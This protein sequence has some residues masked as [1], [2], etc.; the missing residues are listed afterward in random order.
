VKDQVAESPYDIYRYVYEKAC[1]S[2][3]KEEVIDPRPPV[4]PTNPD[5]DS[6]ETEGETGFEVD[7]E[8]SWLESLSMQTWIIFGI[9]LVSVSLGSYIIYKCCTICRSKIKVSKQ[10]TV[11]E[12]DKDDDDPFASP[13]KIIS[14]RDPTTKKNSNRNSKKGGKS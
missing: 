3:Y 4:Q 1:E 11:E 2:E 14:P 10:I 5:G 9:C 12:K 7:E 8:K 6:N 13:R